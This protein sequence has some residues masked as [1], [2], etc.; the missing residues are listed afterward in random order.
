M[1]II[2]GLPFLFF[3]ILFFS[4]NRDPLSPNQPTPP[5]PPPPNPVAANKKPIANAGQD[6]TVNYDLQ[7][8]KATDTI[9]LNGTTSS[10][11]D[12]RI[13]DYRWS[14][15]GLISPATSPTVQ[16]NN[17]PP[18][19][20]KYVLMV[21]DDKAATDTDTVTVNIVSLMN[22]S[23]I[24]VE[25]LPFGVL[26]QPRAGVVA[27][28][29][30]SKILFA[31]GYNSPGTS[32]RV[33]IYDINTNSWSTAELSQARYGIGVT[34]LGTKVFFAGGIEGGWWD[35]ISTYSIVDI[36]DALTNTWSV[37]NLSQARGYVTGASVG[38]KVFFA[39]GIY[40]NYMNSDRV[41]IYDV[42]ANS[43]SIAS[44]SYARREIVAETVNNKIYFAG[45]VGLETNNIN[46]NA[47]AVIDIYD[48]NTGGWSVS[49][50]NEPKA[51][52]QSI[53]MG[54]KIFWAG[55][56]S[57]SNNVEIRDV[58]TQSST[59]TCLSQPMYADHG[60]QKAVCVNNEIHFLPGTVQD[61]FDIYNMTSDTWFIGKLNKNLY[62]AVAISVNNTIYIAGGYVNGVLSN[63]VWKLE[64]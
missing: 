53:V 46:T 57:L 27:A 2:I 58:N 4:C 14:G 55:G 63:Q 7:I 49:A 59:L 39:G 44:L 15:Q 5:P 50:M 3:A 52:F 23:V 43:W 32:T 19:M 51:G 24:N 61:K 25:M 42:V 13:V 6:I 45:G 34:V 29:V 48:S 47:S 38:N 36:Y 9:I 37:A 1:K 62:E 26:S 8:C 21:T 33:D 11:P 40:Q 18:G 10:D 41:D 22:R 20:Y 64:F 30:G 12:G 31:G 28:L 56:G 35:G 16:V 60:C 17:L 54:N